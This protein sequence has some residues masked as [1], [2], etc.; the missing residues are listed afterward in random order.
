MLGVHRRRLAVAADE[1]LGWSM[2]KG[3]QTSDWGMPAL[4]KDQVAYAALDAVAALLLWHRLEAD[5]RAK[6]RWE[7]YV[8]QRDAVPAAVEMETIGIGVDVDALNA[9]IK[10]WDHGLAKARSGWQAETGTPPPKNPGQIRQWLTENL[11][12]KALAEWPR[13]KVDDHLSTSAISLE[14]AAYLPAV[15]PLLDIRRFEKLLSSFGVS[16]RNMISPMTGRI[17][18]NYLVAGTKSGRWSCKSPNLQQMPGER[19]APGFRAIFRA[20]PGRILVGAD[21]SQMELRAA[22]EIS[23]DTALRQVYT[24]GLDL[25]AITAAVMAGINADDVT[26][27]QRSRAKPVNFGSIYGMGPAGLA[28]TAWNGY[29]IEMSLSEAS[30]ALTAFFR[31]FPRLDRWMKENANRCQQRHRIV[32][33]AG[34]VLENAWE[35]NG[36]RYTQCCNL[37]VQGTCADAMMRAVARIHRRIRKEGLNAALVA[38]VHDEVIVE[39]DAQDAPLVAQILEKEMT[40]AFVE[41]FPDAPTTGL[42]DVKTGDSW[43]DLK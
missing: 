8:L 42:V 19:L 6:G 41:T 9:V 25:H 34:R 23:G 16:L 29:R 11:D 1:Y 7:A 15:R 43:A 37:P 26:K 10:K 14:R 24:D 3:F 40:S 17:H 35:P 4:S 33:G 38:Q 39:A 5:L 36:I 18:A 20:P 13:T 27:E 32:I 31:K 22:A 2:P 21:Y 12:P 30:R 28:A